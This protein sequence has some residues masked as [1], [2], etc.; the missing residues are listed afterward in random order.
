[1]ARQPLSLSKARPVIPRVFCALLLALLPALAGDSGKLTEKGDALAA[2][3]RGNEALDHYR[4]AA[5]IRPNDPAI[6][7]R[8]A[9]LQAGQIESAPATDRPALAAEALTLALQAR[10]LA[11]DDAQVRL[12]LAIVYGRVAQTQPPHE[13]FQTARKIKD[14]LEAA[15]A[16]DPREPL[17][18]HVLG[19]WNLELATLNPLL[20][21]IAKAVFGDLP[22]ASLDRAAECFEKSIAYG[23]SRLANY[24]ELGRTLAAQGKTDAARKNLETALAMPPK[25]PEDPALLNQ[26]R[27]TF[28]SLPPPTSSP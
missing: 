12:T 18:W 7:R 27:T 14:E 10:D 23:P 20:R 9:R 1:M 2:A 8:I 6:L 19:R 21:T 22:E 26:A 11:P 25:D 13:K 3:N 5:E 16:R 4:Q 17:A 15:L 28:A 24:A